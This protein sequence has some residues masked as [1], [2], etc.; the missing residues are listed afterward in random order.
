MSPDLSD[1]ITTANLAVV[2]PA[3]KC[4]KQI[5]SVLR[6]VPAFINQV[7][8]VDDASPDSIDEEIINVGDERVTYIRHE[9]NRGVGGAMLT[10]YKKAIE[11]GAEVIIKMDGDGQMDANY[12]PLLIVPILEDKADYTKGNRFLYA[13]SLT[14]MPRQRLLGNIGLTFLT[15]MASGYWNIFDPNNGFTAIHR[16]A[17]SLINQNNIHR[18]YFFESSLLIELNRIRAVVV[19]VPIQAQYGDETSSL[20]L[21]RSL[22]EFPFNLFKGLIRRVVWQYFLYD[23]TAVS[24]FLILGIILT[25]SG[26]LWG[27][28]HWYISIKSNVVTTTGT[29]ML[30]VLPV[31]L[32]FQLLLQALVLDIQNVPDAPLQKSPVFGNKK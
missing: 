9:Q 21:L 18:R 8:I 10:G 19:D 5:G 12:I 29:V 7:I 26:A 24:L 23:F 27:G 1:K 16:Y 15:K 6:S 20:S 2:V 32:G 3:Y 31:I 28:Y 30:S 4:A 25:T 17:L 11:L 13:H 22:F 14:Q